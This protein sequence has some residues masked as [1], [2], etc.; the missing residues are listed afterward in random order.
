MTSRISGERRKKGD[1]SV[2]E[3]WG[4]GGAAMKGEIYRRSEE[5]SELS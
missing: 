5:G 2:K 4:R 1:G 3:W